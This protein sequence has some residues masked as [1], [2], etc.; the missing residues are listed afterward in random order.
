MHDEL[1]SGMSVIW[2]PAAFCHAGVQDS[3]RLTY[4]P[5]SIVLP[6]PHNDYSP[7]L[8]VEMLP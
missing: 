2:R 7:R 6:R 8:E 1:M 4:L 5:I 3:F